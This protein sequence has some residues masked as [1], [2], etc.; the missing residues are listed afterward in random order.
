MGQP[1]WGL[2]LDRVVAAASPVFDQVIAVQ[3][4]GTER[5]SITTIFEPQHEGEAPLFGIAT[6]LTDAR[7]ACFVVA[8][9]YPMITTALLRYLRD[10]RARSSAAIVAPVWQSIPQLLC[11]SYGGG[12]LPVI[13]K[14]IAA[15]KLDVRGL[16]TECATELIAEDDIR[17]RFGQRILDNVNTPADL[18]AMERI[19]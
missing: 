12:V 13:E 16:V 10:R 3:R 14:R 17:A 1:K 11:A 6:A 4:A 5:T 19:P 15:G 9:D 7:G 2:F 18:Q 8:T